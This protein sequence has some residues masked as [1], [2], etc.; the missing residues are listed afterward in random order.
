MNA[1]RI[2]YDSDFV[3]QCR[4][5][6]FYV[7]ALPI[8]LHHFETLNAQVWLTSN[9]I[10]MTPTQSTE[11]KARAGVHS[12]VDVVAWAVFHGHD[13]LLARILPTIPPLDSNRTPWSDIMVDVVFPTQVHASDCSSM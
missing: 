12:F 9:P 4:Q 1:P 3:E 5:D 6:V 11:L 7:E 8:H 13:K 2:G 10:L